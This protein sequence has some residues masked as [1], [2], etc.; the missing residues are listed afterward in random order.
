[1]LRIMAELGWSHIEQNADVKR[2]PLDAQN[3][4]LLKEFYSPSDLI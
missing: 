4:M 3:E 1:M 2:A